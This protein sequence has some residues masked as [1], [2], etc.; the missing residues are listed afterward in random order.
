MRVLETYGDGPGIGEHPAR[1]KK[2]QPYIVWG[3]RLPFFLG[4]EG[5]GKSRLGGELRREERR[6]SRTW[7]GVDREKQ[8]D[9]RRPLRRGPPPPS[10]LA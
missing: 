6:F 9:R 10:T 5:E 1:R 2:R 4:P 3:Y 8:R 7:D